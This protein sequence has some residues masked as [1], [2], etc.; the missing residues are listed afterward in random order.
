[1]K[2]N[3]RSDS[4]WSGFPDK[5]VF[6]SAIAK[7]P[8]KSTDGLATLLFDAYVY[9]LYTGEVDQSRIVSK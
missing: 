5:D 8:M 3:V 6:N 9:V 2:Y 7:Q 4:L 1:M